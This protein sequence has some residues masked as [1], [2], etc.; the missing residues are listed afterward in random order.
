MTL[1]REETETER[2]RRETEKGQNRGPWEVGKRR[3]LGDPFW[4]EPFIKYF[5]LTKRGEKSN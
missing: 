1:N 3:C 4:E 2:Q 5:F